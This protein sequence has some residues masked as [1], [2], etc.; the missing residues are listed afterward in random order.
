MHN[1]NSRVKTYKKKLNKCK[2]IFYAFSEFQYWYG[3]YLDMDQ[4]IVEIRPN[5]KLVGCDIS[6]GKDY[7][8]DFVCVKTNGEILVRECVEKLKLLKPM[9]CKLL[10][11]SRNYWLSKGVEDWGVVVGEK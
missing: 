10:D 8:T 2:K 9:T 4:D 6:D 5:I 7:T 3:N 11:L 1:S